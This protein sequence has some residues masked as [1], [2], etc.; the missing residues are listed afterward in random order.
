MADIDVLT[1]IQKA[2]D[3]QAT[4]LDLFLGDLATVPPE[5][6]QLTNLRRLRLIGKHIE[7]LPSEIGQLENL[8]HL[9]LH[10][11]QMTSL[12]P[13]IGQLARL[14][15]LD[16]Q[17]NQLLSLPPEI[18]QLNSLLWLAIDG[19][20]LTTLP[21][22]MGQLSNLRWLHLGDNRIENLP[23][24]L[25][26]TP[27]ELYWR[28]A[29]L[30]QNFF[31]IN[32][33]TAHQILDQP[34]VEIRRVMLE[35]FG[36]SRFMDELGAQAY[37]Q[38]DFGILYRVDFPNDE[39]LVMVNVTDPSTNRR[40]FLRVPPTIQTAHAAVAWTFG[41]TPDEYKPDKET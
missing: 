8:L 41:M 3:F 16:L 27:L 40:Y 23:A 33:W 20:H 38:D 31:P 30:P 35:R 7:C 10:N 24:T 13:E 6:R 29:R 12:P 34:N 9:Y 4:S 36:E 25:E 21:A 26:T 2:Y 28:A 18:G 5:I 11:S 15:F 32:D 22:E 37:H 14:Q 17:D 39:P 19:N 1:T